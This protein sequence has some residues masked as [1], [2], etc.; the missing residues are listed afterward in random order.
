MNLSGISIFKSKEPEV[1]PSEKPRQH[2]KQEDP[3]TPP[4][5]KQK[6]PVTKDVF[7]R[8]VFFLYC[9]AAEKEMSYPITLSLRYPN[10]GVSWVVENKEKLIDICTFR[11]LVKS[12]VIYVRFFETGLCID[13]ARYGRYEI[14]KKWLPDIPHRSILSAAQIE[15]LWKLLVKKEPS[16]DGPESTATSRAA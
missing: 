2:I 7:I 4:P 1:V 14:S 13:C 6:E 15:E 12:N 3:E 5:K 11:D 16:K 8:T 10:G 9:V